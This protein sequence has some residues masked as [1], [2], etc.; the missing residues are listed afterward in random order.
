[1]SFL[2]PIFKVWRDMFIWLI[3]NYNNSFLGKRRI[4]SILTLLG[5]S[6]NVFQKMPPATYLRGKLARVMAS[7]TI[8]LAA[9][10]LIRVSDP[11]KL[12]TKSPS[13]NVLARVL[14]KYPEMGMM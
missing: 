14:D 13:S 10:S 6:V 8:F 2:G 7:I 12:M 1:M 9:A 11:V 5:V 3:T 4:I